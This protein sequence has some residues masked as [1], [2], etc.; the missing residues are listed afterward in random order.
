MQSLN[1]Q[2]QSKSSNSEESIRSL[3]KI[4]QQQ[5]N[6]LGEFYQQQEEW[7]KKEEAW[8]GEKK[9]L[10]RKVEALEQAKMAGSSEP[11]RLELE[12]S[13]LEERYKVVMQEVGSKDEEIS[14]LKE[15]NEKKAAV[16]GIL[17]KDKEQLEQ[18]VNSLKDQLYEKHEA[19]SELEGSCAKLIEKLEQQEKALQDKDSQIELYLK[20]QQHLQEIIS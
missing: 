11:Q 14:D 15:D 1:R 4:I 8:S 19:Y 13:I 18:A 2:L 5:K 17:K 10:E 16:V 9:R 3:E 20:E 12:Q 7:E 6:L